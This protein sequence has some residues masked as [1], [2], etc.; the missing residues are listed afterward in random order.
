MNYPCTNKVHC[1]SKKCNAPAGPDGMDGIGHLVRDGG[2]GERRAGVMASHPT[3]RI[4]NLRAPKLKIFLIHTFSLIMLL[5]LSGCSGTLPEGNGKASTPTT[6]QVSRTISA[7]S[8][9]RVV[10]KPTVTSDGLKLPATIL[11]TL[12]NTPPPVPLIIPTQ[13][14][15]PI[16]TLVPQEKQRLIDNY[17]TDVSNCELPCWW[18]ITPGQTTWEEAR[19]ILSPLGTE[20]GPFGKNR[21]H[22]YFYTFQQ[23]SEFPPYGFG[24]EIWLADDRVIALRTD[25]Q[26]IK[27]GLDSSLA[28]L[29]KAFGRPDHILVSVNTDSSNNEAP[30]QLELFFPDQGILIHDNG[31]AFLTEKSVI[32]CPQKKDKNDIGPSILLFSRSDYKDYEKLTSDLFGDRTSGISTLI[33][34][35]LSTVSNGFGEEEFFESFS[36]KLSDA[37]IEI[38][39]EKLN[40]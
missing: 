30:Y 26:W 25:S 40:R 15:T 38:S 39:I 8:S 20:D 18:K 23:P 27:T 4:D 2:C 24:L 34:R 6:I 29:L 17:F 14:W 21:L 1:T 11:P 10:E 13:T 3:T 35:R 33:F 9:E 36:D 37:C 28:G 19:Q 22:K 12:T 32:L 7:T 16:P 31:R 5:I